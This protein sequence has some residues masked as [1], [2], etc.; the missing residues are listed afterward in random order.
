MDI[1]G[2]GLS[3]N[4]DGQNVEDPG[5]PGAATP[6]NPN[7]DMI[8][9]VSVLT[10]NYGADNAKGPIVIN[11]L[12]KSGGSTFHGDAHFYGRN[13]ALNSEDAF[14][15]LAE[16]QS[17]YNKGYLVVPSH[18]Y[19]PGFDLGGPVLIPHTRFNPNRN[20]YFFHEAFEAYLQVI[21]G[22]IL[23]DFIPTANM[24]NTGDFSA[25][26]SSG[27]STARGHQERGVERHSDDAVASGKH[28]PPRMLNFRRRHEPG[29]HLAGGTVVDEELAADSHARYSKCKWI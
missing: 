20:K 9:E 5:A 14:A 24:I 18:Y 27:Y 21:D 1:Q 12:S 26:S 23:R 13:S 7:P 28:L 29:L 10:S 3:I 11:A 15:K 16:V 4:E 25:L 19:Y 8:S 17:G 22:G 6:V 2:T